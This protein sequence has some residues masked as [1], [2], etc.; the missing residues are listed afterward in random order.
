MYAPETRF[1]S[2]RI[3][4]ISQP[5]P[6]QEG[7]DDATSRAIHCIYDK[8]LRVVGDDIGIDQRPQVVEICGQRVEL[9]DQA[10]IARF[11]EIHEV[12]SACLFFIVGNIYFHATTLFW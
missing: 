6:L 10:C 5:A 12:G 11:S 7:F 1:I 4:A 2:P 8:A 9:L 3:S